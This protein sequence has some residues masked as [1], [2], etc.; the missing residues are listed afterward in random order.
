M[1]NSLGGYPNKNIGDAF[2]LVWKFRDCD[3]TY[4]H[5]RDQ[6]MLTF[7][8]PM[9]L[10]VKQTADIAIISFVK[11]IAEITRSYTLQKYRSNPKLK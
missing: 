9:N 5:N 1:V 3:T 6:S 8:D 10:C 7:T 11:M 2:L 4:I